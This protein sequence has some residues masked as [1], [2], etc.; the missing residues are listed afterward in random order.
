M[1]ARLCEHD[2]D[3]LKVVERGFGMDILGIKDPIQSLHG[4]KNAKKPEAQW[5][6]AERTADAK[7]VVTFHPHEGTDKGHYTC[8]VPWEHGKPT[9]VNNASAVKMRQNKTLSPT[10]LQKKGASMDE[11]IAYFAKMEKAGY[12]EKLPAN[13]Q[14]EPDSFYLPWFPVIDR[15]RESTKMRIVFDAS[16]KDRNGMS[17]NSQIACTPNRTNDL[18]NIMLGFRKYKYVVTG[19]ISEMFLQIKMLEEDRRYHRFFIGDDLW[20]WTS[21]VFGVTSSPNASQK[22]L[23]INAESQEKAK[24][25]HVVDND[26]YV[27]D[28][29]TCFTEEGNACLTCKEMIESLAKGGFKI[30]KF[31]TNSQQVLDLIPD[32]LLSKKMIFGDKDPEIDASKVLGIIYNANDDTYSYKSKFTD[33]SDFCTVQRIPEPVGWTKRLILKCSATVYDP[34]GFICAFTVRAKAILQSLWHIKLAWDDII[35][36]IERK[37]WNTWMDELFR[38]ESLIKIPRHLHLDN[39]INATLHVFVDASTKVFAAVSYLVVETDDHKELTMEGSEVEN[40]EVFSREVGNLTVRSN[41]TAA[42]GRVTPTKTESVSRL[43]LAACVIGVRLGHTVAKCYDITPEDII[44]WTDSTNCLFWLN[45]PANTLKTFVAHRVGEIQNHSRIT[46]WRHVPTD[47]N[48]ADIPT[49]MPSIEE[50][51]ANKT[52]WNGPQ[53]LLEEESNWPEKF[54]PKACTDEGKNEFKKFAIMASQKPEEY[55]M[56]MDTVNALVIQPRPIPSVERALD[57]KRFSVGKLYDGYE[58]L[59]KVTIIFLRQI[60][61]RIRTQ[62]KIPETMKTDGATFRTHAIKYHLRKAQEDSLRLSE[63][64]IQL[65]KAELP[66]DKMFKR[67]GTPYEK[68][69]GSLDPFLDKEGLIRSNSRLQNCQHLS[70]DTKFPIILD[71][72]GGFTKLLVKSYHQR[73]GHAV[74]EETIKAKLRDKYAIIGLNQMVTAARTGCKVCEIRRRQPFEQRM[75]PIPEYRFEIPLRAFAKTGL[76]FAGPFETKFGRGRARKKVY[77]LVLTCMQ[78]RAVHLEVTDSQDM[79]AVMNAMSR[80][81]DIRGMPTDILSDNFSTFI[82]EDKELQ[83]WVRHL[84]SDLLVTPE[85]AN[86]KWHLTPPHAPHHGGIYETM[87]KATKRALKSINDRQ[88]LDLDEFRTLVSRCGAIINGRPLKRVPDN[89]SII[90]LTPNH[91][92]LGNMGGAVTTDHLTPLQKWKT[93][94]KLQDEYWG[95]L[96]EHFWPELKRLRKWKI[97]NPEVRIDQIVIENLPGLGTGQ[98]RLARVIELIPSS[99]GKV[100]KVKV[101]TSTGVFLRAITNLCPL[102][103]D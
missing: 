11:I 30:T 36:D 25:K 92:L 35:P 81:V 7:M 77:I 90:L 6:N 45:T 102:E 33:V 69:Y 52:W 79:T 12:I 95:I 85:G 49:R 9:L 2:H 13:K 100:R 55:E 82:S 63:L 96:M 42:K 39:A 61:Y 71:N 93:I 94:N 53:F 34:P 58:R 8:T 16:V 74:G 40:T 54:T 43:E 37:E 17:L 10:Y 14:R 22:T 66:K 15:T 23:Q 57:P 20:Q 80:F 29:I 38:L 65:Q 46:N 75:A 56:D 24:A 91:F 83:D 47:I 3:L 60:Y 48:P 18:L 19:D 50:L 103:L 101:K 99:D 62:R 70:Y 97:V 41:I 88:N 73:Y 78:I 98:W 87:V 26:M 4:T 86:V 59:L 32:E 76:D 27:D 67:K 84:D 51:A 1:E 44:Y 5:T 68:K 72:E 31:Y 64:K 21:I 28:M 89:P